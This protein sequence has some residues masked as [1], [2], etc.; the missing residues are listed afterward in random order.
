MYCVLPKYINIDRIL[1]NTWKMEMY[2]K[3]RV[4]R[5]VF[6]VGDSD[7]VLYKNH[8]GHIFQI[9]KCI[10]GDGDWLHFIYGWQYSKIKFFSKLQFPFPVTLF[11]IE[12][13]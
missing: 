9:S 10:T 6:F 12:V 7:Y 13:L 2:T 1:Y 8:T 5:F 11:F 4:R 3:P